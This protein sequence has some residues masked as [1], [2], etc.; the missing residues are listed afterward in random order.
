MDGRI[1]GMGSTNISRLGG[2]GIGLI[3]LAET[4]EWCYFF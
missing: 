3:Y 4:Q 1:F 2:A